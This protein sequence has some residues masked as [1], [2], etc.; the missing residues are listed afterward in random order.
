MGLLNP[1]PSSSLAGLGLRTQGLRRRGGPRAGKKGGKR[2]VSLQI[3]DHAFCAGWVVIDHVIST[4]VAGVNNPA[5]GDGDQRTFAFHHASM[6]R[7]LLG[8][9]HGIHDFPV[10]AVFPHSQNPLV[11]SKQGGWDCMLP[12]LALRKGR[13][14]AP[15][16]ER[17]LHSASHLVF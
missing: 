12:H 9:T 1:I 16:V 15:P 14:L 17:L 2:G 6:L 7:I 4:F 10:K 5:L 8:Q 3:S 11:Q 13:R